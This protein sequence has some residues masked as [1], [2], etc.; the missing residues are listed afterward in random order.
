MKIEKAKMALYK[1]QAKVV[2]SEST[3][4]TSAFSMGPPS[5]TAQA[6]LLFPTMKGSKR[7]SMIVN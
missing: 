4:G 5:K 6:S 1:K 2:D 3:G 7:N